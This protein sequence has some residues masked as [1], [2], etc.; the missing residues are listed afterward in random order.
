MAIPVYAAQAHGGKI[1]SVD[2]PAVV[3]DLAALDGT[4]GNSYAGYVLSTYL[5]GTDPVGYGTF[6]RLIQ[7]VPHDGAVRVEVTPWRDGQDTGQTITRDLAV[8]DNPTVVAPASV[9]GG[10]FQVK[11][12]LSNFD[13]PARLGEAEYVVIQ[14]RSVR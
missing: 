14:R 4:G 13:A 7:R 10:V 1:I 9:T 12:R 11:V 6:R 3:K 5:R 8:G 2:D